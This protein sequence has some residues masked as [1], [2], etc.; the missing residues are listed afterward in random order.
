VEGGAVTDAETDRT[1]ARA[2]IDANETKGGLDGEHTI[3]G[4]T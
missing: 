2:R 4:T 3:V 1:R